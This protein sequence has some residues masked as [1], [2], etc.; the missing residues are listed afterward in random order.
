MNKKSSL[1]QISKQLLTAEL[2]SPA[3]VNLR[4]KVTGRRSDGYHLLSML[5]CLTDFSDTVCISITAD[6]IITVVTELIPPAHGQDLVDLNNLLTNLAARAARLFFDH[7]GLSFGAT[8]Q[9]EKRI[10]LGGGLGGGSG[11][12]A[13]V[14]KH[15]ARAFA[16]QLCISK[17]IL[18]ELAALIGSDV[19]FMLEG[20]LGVVTGIGERVKTF[21]QHPLA[22]EP[23]WLILPPFGIETATVFAELRKEDISTFTQDLGLDEFARGLNSGQSLRED[24]LALL[25]NDLL[26]RAGASS[27]KIAAF[28]QQLASIPSLAA[29]M[30]GSGSTLFAVSRAPL[31]GADQVNKVTEMLRQSFES[32]GVNV[33]QTLIL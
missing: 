4:L 28:H 31:K 23:I 22:Q 25:D 19:P 24:V 26:A 11:N 5:N 12:A 1:N 27:P 32:Q 6:P 9:I 33:I 10:P 15:L 13:V 8:I 14:L 30:S 2:K 29:S 7:F 3:K 17:E 20:G 21:P 16:D 18:A